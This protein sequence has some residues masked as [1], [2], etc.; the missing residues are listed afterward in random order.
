M[1]VFPLRVFIV[2]DEAL[3]R[4]R[5]KALLERLPHTLPELRLEI[6]GE[7]GEAGKAIRPIQE[8]MPDVLFLDIEMPGLDGFDLLEMLGE[9]RPHIVFVT[10]YDTYAVNAF[11][12]KAV[13]YL[14][15]P[16]RLSRLAD[17]LKRIQELGNPATTEMAG[18]LGASSPE[19]PPLRRISA[20]SATGIEIIELDQ[21][22]H[23]E[24]RGKLV[25]VHYDSG[26]KRV[27]FTLDELEN[28]LPPAEFLRIHRSAIVRASR[29]RKIEPWFSGNWQAVMHNGAKLT[30]ARRRVKGIKAALGYS[31]GH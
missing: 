3:A 17:C 22:Q 25:Y 7:S 30:I 23:F 4:H 16:V 26:K 28:R 10:A 19:E 6:A 21:V 15:K 18:A 1:P 20:A 2:D 5:L 13:D 8:T 27:D 31:K 24:T 14:T 11:D 12:V 9:N 29:I